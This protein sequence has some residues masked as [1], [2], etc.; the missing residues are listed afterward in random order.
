MAFKLDAFKNNADGYLGAFFANVCRSAWNKIYMG[1]TGSLPF[2]IGNVF[3]HFVFKIPALVILVA[4]KRIEVGI[5]AFVGALDLVFAAVVLILLCVRGL[6]QNSEDAD[7]ADP[8]L[9]PKNRKGEEA[10]ETNK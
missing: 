1:K 5:F 6:R 8:I 2:S 10:A 7:E 9:P 4:T 3:S